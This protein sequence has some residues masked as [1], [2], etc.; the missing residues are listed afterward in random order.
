MKK[1]VLSAL[2]LSA[3]MVVAAEIETFRLEAM[4]RARIYGPFELAKGKRVFIGGKA[5]SLGLAAGKK[6]SFRSLTT[7]EL[8]GPY[9]F[10]IGRIVNIGGAHYT[11]VD[12]ERMAAP[13]VVPEPAPPAAAP[14][15]SPPP[16]PCSAGPE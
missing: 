3:G 12:I 6:V 13:D 7:D 14:A 16:E 8:H 15:F 5:Y 2:L 11:L 9:D 4:D 1:L 10:I